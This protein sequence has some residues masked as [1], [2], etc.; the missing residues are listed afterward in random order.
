M[1]EG[2]SI[3]GTDKFPHRFGSIL[4]FFDIEKDSCPDAAAIFGVVI[5]VPDE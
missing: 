4:S 3:F 5:N 1:Q 2:T